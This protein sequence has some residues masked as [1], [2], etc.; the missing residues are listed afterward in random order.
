M[1]NFKSTDSYNFKMYSDTIK[2]WIPTIGE[3]DLRW[4]CN[5]AARLYKQ[6]EKMGCVD[7]FRASRVC[8]VTS[9]VSVRY[10][11]AVKSGCCGSVDN[12]HTNERTGN[13]FS[14]GFNYGH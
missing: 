4:L 7:N 6:C 12:R 2:C 3:D 13:T 5:R 8:K 1:D 9:S 14:I 10:N 11:D